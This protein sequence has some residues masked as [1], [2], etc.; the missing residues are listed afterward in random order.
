MVLVLPALALE[1]ALQVAGHRV[2][3]LP[4]GGR[5]LGGLPRG[6]A[7]RLGEPDRGLARHLRHDG[8]GLLADRALVPGG[9]VAAQRGRTV[10]LL[11][12]PIILPGLLQQLLGAGVLGLGQ[13]GGGPRV[14]ALHL[15]DRDLAGEP[16]LLL[17][18]TFQLGVPVQ[19]QPQRPGV[20]GRGQLTAH[21]L[22]RLLGLVHRVRGLSGGDPGSGDRSG[23]FRKTL[24]GT[25]GGERA[26][27]RVEGVPGAARRLLGGPRRPQPRHRGLHGGGQ[28]AHPC[29][30]GGRLLD[31]LLGGVLQRGQRLVDHGQLGLR[32]LAPLRGPDL[33]L[34]VDLQAQQVDQDLLPGGRLGVQEI[35]ELALRQHHATGELLVGQ[36][37]GVQHRVVHLG[38]DAGQDLA[39]ILQVHAG[40]QLGHV[41]AGRHQ[42]Q[43]GAGRLD[44][45]PP[46]APDHAGR[47]VTVAGR[48]EDQADPGLDGGRGERVAD[49]TGAAPAR[50]LAVERETDRVQHRRLAR[51]GRAD[52]GEVVGVGEIHGGLVTEHREPGHVQPDGPHWVLLTSS[53]SASKSSRT[54]SS[55]LPRLSR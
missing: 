18:E 33:H 3:L 40:V 32:G 24:G 8:D 2:A 37:D 51:A 11:G 46:V 42:L 27:L 50:D 38:G 13:V 34:L 5:L 20:A 28:L 35:G 45:A 14:P 36:A 15:G 53:Y 6:G 52:Q 30:A 1:V 12:V 49:P 31:G 10:T 26:E 16:R 23:R 19:R 17:D 48:L 44:V 4:A 47:D 7:G 25:D 9:Q 21:L 22:L 39:E 55:A 43:P 54:P 41:E 29:Q